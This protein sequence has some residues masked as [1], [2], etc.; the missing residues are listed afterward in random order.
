MGRPEAEFFLDGLEV[1]LQD[2]RNPEI[3]HSQAAG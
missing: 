1:P 2:G 3:L